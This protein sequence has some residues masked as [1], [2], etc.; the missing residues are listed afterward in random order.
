MMNFAVDFNLIQFGSCFTNSEACLISW[1][2]DARFLEAVA[3]IIE[4][5]PTFFILAFL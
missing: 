1:F 2:T 5:L 3:K 4:I